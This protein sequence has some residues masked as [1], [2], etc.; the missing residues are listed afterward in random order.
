MRFSWI[1][2]DLIGFTWIV[3]VAAASILKETT[4]KMEEATA[5]WATDEEA[6]LSMETA[7]AWAKKEQPALTTEEA[8]AQI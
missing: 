6:A 3:K 5:T 2:V 8:A 4:S 1:Q 7:A